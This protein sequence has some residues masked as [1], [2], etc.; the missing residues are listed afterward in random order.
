MSEE[1]IKITGES[2][3]DPISSTTMLVGVAGAILLLVI[4]V[5][6]Q[7]LYLGAVERERQRKVLAQ[8]PAELIEV[9]SEQQDTLESYRW[10]DKQQGIAAIPIDRAM[11]LVIRDYQRQAGREDGR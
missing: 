1:R 4:G 7:A 9:L 6:L 10:V 8:P 11:E 3:D 5:L 2:A